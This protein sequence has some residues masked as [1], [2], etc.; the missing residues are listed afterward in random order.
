VIALGSLLDLN[1]YSLEATG[2]R[3]RIMEEIRDFPSIPGNAET[4]QQ[5]AQEICAVVMQHRLHF[6]SVFM[7]S[8]IRIFDP[9]KVG[10]RMACE[11][12]VDRDVEASELGEFDE[13][14]GK[15]L[16][17]QEVLIDAYLNSCSAYH[18]A[19]FL[20]EA[21]YEVAFAL[22]ITAVES[23]SNTYYSEGSDSKRFQRFVMEFLPEDKAF[24]PSERRYLKRELTKKETNAHLQKLL[25]AAYGRLRSGF[26]HFG[27]SSPLGS[28]LADK[29]QIAYVKTGEGKPQS[30]GR[31]E[32]EVLNPSFGWFKRIVGEVLLRFLS[33][34][35]SGER[36]DLHVLTLPSF[37]A[38]VKAGKSP[39]K[40]GQ[41]VSDLDL[42]LQ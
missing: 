10:G 33:L 37:M 18:S 19:L 7:R 13:A 38:R 36:R 16:S 42:E 26:A 22:L 34:Q 5:I 6:L 12:F 21:N 25:K 32:H 29:L 9:V 4:R 1:G 39:I 14:F 23:L 24:L 20:R 31:E 2:R 8:S 35:K 28:K 15:M 11:F 41:Q 40:A 3:I 30:Q 17:M 27:R